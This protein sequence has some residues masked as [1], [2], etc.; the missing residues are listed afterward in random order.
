G[1][2]VVARQA[3]LGDLV[4]FDMGGTSTDVCLVE[5]GEPAIA[6]EASV[7]GLPFRTPSVAVHTVGAGGGSLLWIDPAGALRAGPASAGAVPGPACYGGGP[8]RTRPARH[9]VGG[10]RVAHPPHA[11]AGP[12]RGGIGLRRPVPPGLRRPRSPGGGTGCDGQEDRLPLP[13]PGPRGAGGGRGGLRPRRPVQV[14]R[15]R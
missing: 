7:G 3:G 12:R 13:G 6:S 11:G 4:T 8:L 2:V 9:P 15:R 5:G 10:G 1:A 14:V